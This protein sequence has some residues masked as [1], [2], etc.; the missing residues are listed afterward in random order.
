MFGGTYGDKQFAN[1]YPIQFEKE[2]DTIVEHNTLTFATK[3]YSI[4][5]SGVIDSTVYLRNKIINLKINIINNVEIIKNKIMY[6]K[7]YVVDL[8]ITKAFKNITIPPI[9]RAIEVL[10]LMGKNVNKLAIA[11]QNILIKIFKVKVYEFEFIGEF[12]P[13]DILQIDTKNMRVLINGENALHLVGND[14][15]P[16]VEPENSVFIYSD[17]ENERSI[18]ITVRWEDRWL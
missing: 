13:N 9:E 16:Y 4:F 6:A 5:I 1:R 17:D 8:Q 15:F 11:L 2:V 18:K 12:N 14:N 10:S 7:I 3:L